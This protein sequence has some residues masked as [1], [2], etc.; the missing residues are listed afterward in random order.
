MLNAIVQEW[1]ISF[2]VYGTRTWVTQLQ[3]NPLIFHVFEQLHS[4]SWSL[5]VFTQPL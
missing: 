2:L 3:Q 4:W 1:L 5:Y